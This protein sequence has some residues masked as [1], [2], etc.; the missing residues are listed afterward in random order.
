MKVKVLVS[1]SGLTL[2]D[3]MDCSPSDSSVHGILQAGILEWVA[4]PFSRGLPDPRIEPRSPAQQ[5][6]SLPFEPPGKPH[7]LGVAQILS[8]G[9]PDRLGGWL[10]LGDSRHLAQRLSRAC[11]FPLGTGVIQRL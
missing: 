8:L 2:C 4:I 5:A 9:L 6:D 1:H 10:C 11:F 3:P 7:S